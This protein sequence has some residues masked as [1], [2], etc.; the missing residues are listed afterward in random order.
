[1]TPLSFILFFFSSCAFRFDTFAQQTK[2]G[3]GN[4]RSSKRNKSLVE[5]NCE[6][7]KILKQIGGGVLGEL[8]TS[9]FIAN[10]YYQSALPPGVIHISVT[11][12]DIV[13]REHWQTTWQP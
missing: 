2:T 4:A 12:L 1:M 7:R 5:R 9:P 3:Q 11:S 13:V 10:V 6:Q 8:E